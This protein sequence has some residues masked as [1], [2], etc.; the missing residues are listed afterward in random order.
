MGVRLLAAAA[1]AAQLVLLAFCTTA[2]ASPLCP[3]DS[4]QPSMDNAYDAA[5]SVVCDINAYRTQ[6]GLQPVRWDWRLWSGA[7]QLAADMAARHYAAHVTPEGKG[8]ADRIQPTGYIPQ[9]ANWS[10]S[11]NLGWGTSYLS[12]P[13]SIVIGW[14]NSPVHRENLL[15]PDI[16]DVGVGMAKG[17][18][19]EGGDVGIVYVADFGMRETPV[20]TLRIRGKIVRHVRVTPV[21]T[22]R[23]RGRS[24]RSRGR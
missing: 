20:D 6:N 12:T 16:R 18:V 10:L 3:D 7:Q 9:T 21:D 15:D 23:I 5:M 14:I 11:E 1:V 8:L 24:G 4:T 22:L 17:A 13:L 2:S 19:T